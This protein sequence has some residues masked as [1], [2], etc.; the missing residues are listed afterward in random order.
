MKY[1]SENEQYS[2]HLDVMNWPTNIIEPHV[3]SITKERYAFL[4]I[5]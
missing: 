3:C 5:C 4:Y 1:T 2:A